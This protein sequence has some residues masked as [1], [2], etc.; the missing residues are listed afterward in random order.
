MSSSKVSKCH[1]TSD[2]GSKE[3]LNALFK[4]MELLQAKQE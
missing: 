4:I 1:A 2:E 3:P